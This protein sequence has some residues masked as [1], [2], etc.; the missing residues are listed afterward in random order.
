MTRDYSTVFVSFGDSRM[1][2]AAARIGSQAG[3][4][5]AFDRIHVWNENDLD[6]DFRRRFVDKLIIGSKGYGFWCWKPRVI[7][8][9]LESMRD[10]DVVM[11]TDI[12]CHLVPAGRETLFEY[13]ECARQSPSGIFGFAG[14]GPNARLAICAKGDLLAYFGVYDDERILN[15][16][17]F[18]GATLV[19]A[20]KPESVAFMK[21]WEQAF[22]DGFELID[23]S[24]SIRPD[25]PGF[26]R[27]GHDQASLSILCALHGGA[28]RE[29]D[30]LE[31]LPGTVAKP[32][33]VALLR[34]K[35]IGNN[36]DAFPRALKI[37]LG[38]IPYKPLRKGIG[39]WYKRRKFDRIGKELRRKGLTPPASGAERTVNVQGRERTDP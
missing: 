6:P 29:N 34:D 35:G 27:S 3:A 31:P 25:K 5:N 4:M 38:C 7:G 15:S 33:P 17:Y 26:L 14:H 32:G 9:C 37:L 8:M 18:G 24:P 10:G 28:S 30:R 2:A 1:S 11:Y 23:D 36:S 22:A 19:A 39:N 21:R 13:F 16:P 20:K 12:G